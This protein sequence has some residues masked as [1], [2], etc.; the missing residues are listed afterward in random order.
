[1]LEVFWK[2]HIVSSPLLDSL[3]TQP[4]LPCLTCSPSTHQTHLSTRLHK[5]LWGISVSLAAKCFTA[6]PASRL[7]CLYCVLKQH[8]WKQWK[9]TTQSFLVWNPKQ[10]AAKKLVE[11][12]YLA[13]W[14]EQAPHVKKLL[15]SPQADL[16]HFHQWFLL[17]VIPLPVSVTL[18]FPIN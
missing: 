4:A 15:S 16:V 12:R 17:R 9:W 3:D 1:M 6:L 2:L 5:I 13:R 10:W 8:W 11:G 18:G 7:V 14:V